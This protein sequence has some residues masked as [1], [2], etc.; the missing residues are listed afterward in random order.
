MNIQR[1][2]LCFLDIYYM[3]LWVLKKCIYRY[4]IQA[5]TIILLNNKTTISQ[6]WLMSCSQMLQVEWYEPLD[7]W[8]TRQILFSHFFQH[9]HG[10]SCGSIIILIWRYYSNY[11]TCL[12]NYVRR[13]FSQMRSELENIVIE[14]WEFIEKYKSKSLSY[15]LN[16]WI[17]ALFSRLLEWYTVLA[18][19][20]F[21]AIV[22]FTVTSN[23]HFDSFLNQ[24]H[25]NIYDI[26]K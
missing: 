11:N 15:Y 22:F 26:Q 21:W 1:Q 2:S 13:Y 25:L 12:L 4:S 17:E 18:M 9:S 5:K 16:K 8:C 6:H 24:K 10:N 7:I 23:A 20:L 14:N 3:N 19:L